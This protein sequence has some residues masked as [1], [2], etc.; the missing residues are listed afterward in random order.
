[1]AIQYEDLDAHVRE[2]MVQEIRS[3]GHYESPVRARHIT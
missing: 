3:G 2:L 1:M